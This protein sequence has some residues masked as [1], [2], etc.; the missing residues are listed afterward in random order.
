MDGP[1]IF[2]T[3]K[4]DS[5]ID[6]PKSLPTIF[7]IKLLAKPLGVSFPS[8]HDDNHTINVTGVVSQDYKPLLV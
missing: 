2:H 7:T 4:W 3:F 6:S 5:K 8:V 1:W